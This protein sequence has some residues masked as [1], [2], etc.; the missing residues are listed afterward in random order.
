[1]RALAVN[2]KLFYQCRRLW[3]WYV[4]LMAFGTAAVLGGLEGNDFIR[5]LFVSI[6]AGMLVATFQREILSKPFSFCMPGHRNLMRRLFLGIG[7]IVNFLVGMIF[8]RYPGI[9]FPHTLFVVTAACFAGMIAYLLIIWIVLRSKT[10][11]PLTLLFCIIL[12]AFIHPRYLQPL[13]KVIASY[14]VLIIGGG[15]VTCGIGWRW[16]GGNS[17]A[18]RYCGEEVVG[19]AD[20]WSSVKMGRMRRRRI[21][22]KS[23]QEASLAYELT[24]RLFLAGMRKCHPLGARR[25]ILGTLHI[26]FGRIF[27]PLWNIPVTLSMLIMGI[28]LFGYIVP[29]GMSAFFFAMPALGVLLTDLIPHRSMVLPAG[30][31]ERFRG[32]LVSGLAIAVMLTIV[33]ALL[34]MMIAKLSIPLAEL[35]PE[36][37]LGGHIIS[38]HGIDAR[39]SYLCLFVMPIALAVGTLFSRKRLSF[40]TSAALT[41]AGIM[42]LA[43]AITF[44]AGTMAL[45]FPDSLL[46]VLALV[47]VGWIIFTVAVGYHCRRQSLVTQGG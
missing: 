2:L 44:S 23:S 25:Y 28:I 46:G 45:L 3:F 7:A 31:A 17:L 15:I 27:W 42:G 41:I 47:A 4:P 16:L 8:F 40:L 22:E 20:S 24:E 19:A 26:I 35:L 37:T 30:R 13:A 1:M 11:A 33:S 38:F 21:L 34:V 32:A 12:P 43:L 39:K 5:Y 36:R 10:T 14:P 29:P 18:R 6:L 9:D